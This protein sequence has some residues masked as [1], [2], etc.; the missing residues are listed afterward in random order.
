MYAKIAAI[1]DEIA[2]LLRDELDVLVREQVMNIELRQVQLEGKPQRVIIDHDDDEIRQIYASCRER[3][4]AVSCIASPI[5]KVQITD[6]FE[7]HLA[8]FRRA[9]RAAELCECR[10]VRIFSFY[11]PPEPDARR[12]YRDEVMRRMRALAETARQNHPDIMLVHENEADI[13]GELPEQCLDII[14][15]VGAPNLRVNFDPANF[16]LAGVRPFTQGY[17]LLRSYIEYVHIKDARMQDRTITPAGEGDGEIPELLRALKADGYAGYFSLE[18][19]LAEAHRS[20]GV[21]G[22]ELFK[23]AADALKRELEK[24]G[25]V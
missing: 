1:A 6:D 5:G 11:L 18:P 16:V 10:Y 8:R 4:I 14:E 17:P 2:P 20:Y 23:V 3:G 9:L 21:T 13:Y 25:Y 22:P 19:H 7:A 24:A 15:S 12:R